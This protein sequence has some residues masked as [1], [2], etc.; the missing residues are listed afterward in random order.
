MLARS[1]LMRRSRSCDNETSTHGNFLK[2]T[3]VVIL[4][5]KNL[6][7]GKA[8]I[9][10]QP[11]QT[12]KKLFSPQSVFVYSHLATSP[13]ENYM[14][15]SR[16]VFLHILL[17]PLLQASESETLKR[18]KYFKTFS[19]SFSP[20]RRKTSTFVAHKPA[21]KWEKI[22]TFFPVS[23]FFR[24]HENG[25]KENLH[26]FVMGRKNFCEKNE[27]WINLLPFSERE[28]NSPPRCK[29]D[30]AHELLINITF[31]WHLFEREK[32]LLSFSWIT[33]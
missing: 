11:I 32:N 22:S 1:D 12:E 26:R 18:K 7:C 24:Q 5:R 25:E 31:F 30:D 9:T 13:R 28:K 8:K 16:L 21:A 6:S 3:H 14:L 19:F 27:N 23:F 4:R 29:V 2:S 33:I 10:R 20:S 15:N 17:E